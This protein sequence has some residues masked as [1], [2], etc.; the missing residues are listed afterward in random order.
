MKNQPLV[1]LKAVIGG[2]LGLDAITIG[3]VMAQ[4]GDKVLELKGRTV[5]D[6]PEVREGAIIRIQLV[7]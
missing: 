3:R 5:G 6:C 2:A 7:V 4:A 1:E